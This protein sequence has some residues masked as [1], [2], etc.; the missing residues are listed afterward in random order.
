MKKY[1]K[2]LSFRRKREGKTDYK[3]RLRLL[4]SGKARMVI[5]KS[6]KNILIQLIQ[7]SV[8]GDKVM[9][10]AHSN[11][12]RKFGWKGAKRNIPAAYL[13]G[14]LFGMKAKKSK[15]GEAIL[16]TGMAVMIKG[17]LLYASLKGAL[18]AGLQ[19]PHS[20][21]IFPSEDRICGKHIEANTVTKTTKY[22]PKLVPQN[23]EEV[24]KKIMDGVQ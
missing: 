5:R 11:E 13:T 14:L 24:K 22:D 21:G 7:L 20:D 2:Q 16:D 6:N 19:V 18:D 12:L 4:S 23:F 15:I 8:E 10:S 3:K 9:V 1:I 17:S